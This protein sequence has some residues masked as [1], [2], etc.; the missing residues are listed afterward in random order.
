[1]EFVKA[2]M[3]MVYCTFGKIMIKVK[4]MVCTKNSIKTENYTKNYNQDVLVNKLIIDRYG[5]IIDSYP[6]NVIQ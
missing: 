1:M 3:Q 4:K 2:D 5:K 6:K